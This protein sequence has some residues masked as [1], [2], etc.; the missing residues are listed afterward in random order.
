[1]ATDHADDPRFLVQPDRGLLLRGAPGHP[2]LETPER[3]EHLHDRHR[4]ARLEP[5]RR[6]AGEPVVGVDQVIVD[7]PRDA[8]RLDSV[9][10]L[11]KVIVDAHPGHRGF[12]AR[13]QVD[14]ASALAEGHHAGDRRVLRA[15]EDVDRHPHAA[16]LARNLPDVHVHPARFLAAQRGQ[17]ARVHAQHRDVQVHRI[18]TW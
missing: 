5:E 11:V 8:P 13:R 2:V 6:D 17:R 16:E 9:D 15:R 18:L 7:R 3:V 4:P 12:V 1:M 10:E 14:H